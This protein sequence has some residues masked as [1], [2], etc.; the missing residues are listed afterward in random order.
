MLDMEKMG[1]FIAKLRR[2]AGLTQQQVADRLR[3]SF[4]AV[5]KWEKGVSA[6]SLELLLP[7]SRLLG[8]SAD[9]LLTG[10]EET[11]GMSYRAAGVDIAYTD[12]IKS[13]MADSI[14]GDDPRV[15][16]GLGPFASLYDLDFPELRRPLLV[17]KAEE[18]GSKQKLAVQYGY[19]TSICH[20]LVNHLVN[21]IAV[22]GARPLAV[23]DT[24]ICGSAERD[25]I[26][27]LVAGIAAACRENGCSLVGGETSIQ[28]QVI[29]PGRYILCAA[30]AGI[31]PR[32]DLIDGRAI[33]PGD[34]VLALASN[35]L[36]TNGYT[37]VRA[38]M[39]QMPNLL[40]ERVGEETFLEAVMRPHT[41]YYP[42]LKGL[43]PHPGVHGLAHI[44]GGGIAGNLARILPPSVDARIDLAN[45]RPQAI[46]SCIKRNG[47]I[48]DGEMLATFNCGVGLAMVASAQDAQALRTRLGARIDCYEIGVIEPGCGQVRLEGAVGWE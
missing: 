21:D 44:T 23:L 19:T 22:M 35:G 7:L 8:V 18:P 2:Q 27:S 37:L 12:A 25:T 3:V 5:S 42:L 10:R 43:L 11:A 40:Q 20:D 30:I 45:L 33:V 15:L 17:L 9:A 41:A 38:M 39:D 47:N 36:H 24:I 16:N 14:G 32:A 28:P 13:L 46:F 1:G 29:D 6:P 31:V 26:A 4:Q 34:R 48:A